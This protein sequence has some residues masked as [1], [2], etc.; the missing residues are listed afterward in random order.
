MPAKRS[1]HNKNYR[2]NVMNFVLKWVIL[3]IIVI[4]LGICLEI[5]FMVRG[6]YVKTFSIDNLYHGMEVNSWINKNMN[7]ID[8]IYDLYNNVT[9]NKEITIKLL[10]TCLMKQLPVNFIFALVKQ[11][12]MFNP[13]ARNV[14]NNKSVDCGL[15]QLNSLV[16]KKYID[17]GGIQY[18]FD[19]ENNITF[20]TE[21]ILEAYKDTKDWYA[22]LGVYN[23]GSVYSNVNNYY[24][25]NIVKYEQTL[26][27]LFNVFVNSIGGKK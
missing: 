5:L 15:F 26:D 18:L 14:N 20:G 6:A 8:S 2:L 9:K 23:R 17:A 22:A 12:S 10:H 4:T 3:V 25:S 24:L 19:I 27:D 13:N 11:E 21:H 16:Y 7:Y 1:I